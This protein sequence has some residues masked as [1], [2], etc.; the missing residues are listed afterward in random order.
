MR[1]PEPSELGQL[2]SRHSGRIFANGWLLYLAL[3][4]A[5]GSAV[6]AVAGKWER[7]LV[8]K[9]GR[10]CEA[11]RWQEVADLEAE[12]IEDDFVLTVTTT[13]DR[14]LQ[15][16]SLFDVLAGSVSRAHG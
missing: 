16:D 3:I 7:G 9:R 1:P 5:G 10:R 13:K 11:V 15:H 6:S 8:G 4:V 2:L 14:V 12:T